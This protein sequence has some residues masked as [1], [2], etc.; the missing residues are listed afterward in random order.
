[1]VD[2]HDFGVDGIAFIV[3]A[4]SFGEELGVVVVAVEME[5]RGGETR[6]ELVDEVVAFRVE[7]AEEEHGG[8]LS[9]G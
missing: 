7:V 9:R 2:T 3:G 5:A 8:A 4:C 1:M 6:G